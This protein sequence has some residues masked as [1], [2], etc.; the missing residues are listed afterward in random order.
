[1]NIFQRTYF[2]KIWSKIQQFSLKK[3]HLKMSS[4]KWQPF[5]LCFNVLKFF[6]IADEDPFLLYGQNH[7]CWLPGDTWSQSMNSYGMDLII[8]ECSGSSMRKVNPLYAK[9]LQREQKHIFTF[10]VIPPC[11]HDTGN[12]NPSLSKTRTYL[13]YIVNIMAADVL[14][15]QGARASAT[16]ILT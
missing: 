5:C 6:I 16:M 11:W 4:G 1:M 9:F 12:W 3:M 13:F 8:T 10:Y 7:G 2:S 15:T 14:A